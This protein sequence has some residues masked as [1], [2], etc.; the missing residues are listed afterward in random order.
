MFDDLYTGYDEMASEGLITPSE[1]VSTYSV[2]TTSEP[3]EEPVEETTNEETTVEEVVVDTS[4]D[5]SEENTVDESTVEI[6]E[7]IDYTEQL[8]LMNSHLYDIKALA[9]LM[10]L[11][12]AWT[13]ISK[14]FNLRR[15]DL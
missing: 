7:Q 10:F 2:D 14:T 9:L 3:S 6:I 15:R 8:E 13:L 1:G 12:M 11:I 5:V 4:S